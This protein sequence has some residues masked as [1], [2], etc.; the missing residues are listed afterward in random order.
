[1]RTE[2]VG[3]YAALRKA[4]GQ[5]RPRTAGSKLVFRGQ[6][7]VRGGMLLPSIHRRGASDYIRTE[8]G[9][10]D[11]VVTKHLL[12]KVH[13]YLE[14]KKSRPAGRSRHAEASEPTSSAG[15]TLQSHLRQTFQHYGG[16]SPY[17]D[18][19]SSLNVALWFAHH[20]Y[21]SQEVVLLPSDVP[22]LVAPLDEFGPMPAYNAAWYEPAW[23]AKKGA[24]GYVIVLEPAADRIGGVGGPSRHGHLIDLRRNKS[25]MRIS[26]QKGGLMYADGRV[27]GGDLR[28][29]VRRI[30]RFALPLRG[31]PQSV[32]R[33]PTTQLFPS[34][35]V[36]L[37]LR[38]LLCAVPFRTD[39]ARPFVLQRPLSIPEYYR[40][41]REVI[42][43]RAWKAYRRTDAY[44]PRTFVFGALADGDSPA[45]QTS[46]DGAQVLL[47]DALPI[48]APYYYAQVPIPSTAAE[49]PLPEGQRNVF[50]EFDDPPFAIRGEN[51]PIEP[52]PTTGVWIVATPKGFWCRVFLVFPS[53][54]GSELS[55]TPGTVYRVED[56]GSEALGRAFREASAT[57]PEVA[58]LS[59]TLGLFADLFAGRRTVGGA[60]FGLYRV[61]S[62]SDRPGLSSERPFD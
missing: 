50:V 30:F 14:W 52:S 41:S 17:L 58:G 16:R 51:G 47:R 54:E 32:T 57:A 42:G 24:S 43:S 48:L 38:D 10:W 40:S 26:R 31:M 4:I 60:P 11:K 33:T 18:V 34:P 20:T 7:Q 9:V 53:P 15:G 6:T 27:D 46:L 61:L 36:D 56:V 44:L 45:T 22:D 2:L 5:L 8:D 23:T 35:A 29:F 62:D 39:L 37:T 25:S 1:M 55:I 12:T 3:S 19:T 28:S 49:C 21:C 59:L 13:A